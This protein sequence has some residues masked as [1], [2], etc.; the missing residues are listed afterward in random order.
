MGADNNKEYKNCILEKTFPDEITD[1]YQYDSNGEIIYIL[2]KDEKH[3]E[4]PN[5]NIKIF[6]N[7]RRQIGLIKEEG[8]INIFNKYTFYNENNQIIKTVEKNILLGAEGC[9]NDLFKYTFYDENRNI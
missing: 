2:E 5:R 1:F 8:N 3:E 7:E 9:C 6:D 4:Y